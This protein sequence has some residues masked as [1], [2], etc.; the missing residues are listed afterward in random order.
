MFNKVLLKCKLKVKVSK[1]NAIFYVIIVAFNHIHLLKDAKVRGFVDSF[2]LYTSKLLQSAEFYLIF[3][4]NRDYNIKGQTR[5]KRLRQHLC[6]HAL[7]LPLKEITPKFTRTKIKL[8]N[9]TCDELLDHF[10]KSRCQ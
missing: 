8:I 6:S 1:R 10:I 5:L 2:V 4:R 7:A 3:D 9:I